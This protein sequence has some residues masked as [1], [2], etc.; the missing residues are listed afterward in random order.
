MAKFLAKIETSS[1]FKELIEGMKDVCQYLKLQVSSKGLAMQGIDQSH[2][3]ITHIELDKE[4]FMEFT[5]DGEE[6]LLL[7]LKS[8][9]LHRVLRACSP[10]DILTLG[11]SDSIDAISLVFESHPNSAI[12][13]TSTFQLGLMEAEEAMLEIPRKKYSA[14]IEM[15]SMDFINTLRNASGNSAEITFVASKKEFKM[16]FLDKET[17]GEIELRES[18][19]S[20]TKL[21]VDSPV[22]KTFNVSLLLNVA[23]SLQLAETVHVNLSDGVPLLLA[24]DLKDKTG[25]LES[26]VAPKLGA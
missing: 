1:V 21:N 19:G 15:N 14:C 10:N 7:M 22:E 6:S 5:F 16:I 17:S 13:R 11:V 9:T 8:D 23:K 4:Y 20:H 26:H 24:I 18:K 25:R 2:V 12:I 3:S